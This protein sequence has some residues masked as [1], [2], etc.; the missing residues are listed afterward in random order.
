MMD[1]FESDHSTTEG[2]K[3][4]LLSF[5]ELSFEKS[6]ITF[7]DSCYKSKKGIPTGGCDSPQIADIFL[8][9]LT[10]KKIKM[11]LPWDRLIV[12]FLQYID[13]CFPKLEG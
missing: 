10:H 5:T 2:I 12:L 13:D 1:A 8:H 7:Q 11:N 6:G 9:W 4:A 3:E